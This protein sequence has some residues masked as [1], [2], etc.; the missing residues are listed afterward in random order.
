[1]SAESVTFTPT[2]NLNRPYFLAFIQM[3]WHTH[4][5]NKVLLQAFRWLSQFALTAIFSRIN[6]LQSCSVL[7]W[8]CTR[9]WL[10]L[11]FGYMWDRSFHY[12]HRRVVLWFSYLSS[13]RRF[14]LHTRVLRHRL[15][16][17]KRLVSVVNYRWCNLLLLWLLLVGTLLHKLHKRR[18]HSRLDFGFWAP[19]FVLFSKS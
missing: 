8:I 11:R 15:Q 18:G 12:I 13:V 2:R 17:P 19:F 10:W 14:S 5:E 16:F 9:G 3:T 4:L 1:M 6:G 7:A